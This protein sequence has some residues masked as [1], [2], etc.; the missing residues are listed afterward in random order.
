V[1]NKNWFD[2]FLEWVEG[3]NLFRLIKDNPYADRIEGLSDGE[4]FSL[5]QLKGFKKKINVAMDLPFPIL[6]HFFRHYDKVPDNV[7]IDKDAIKAKLLKVIMEDG[8]TIEHFIDAVIEGN[9]IVGVGLIT[10]GDKL[11]DYCYNKIK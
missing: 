11:K 4:V 2:T 10:L 3:T 8:A 6:L 5:H 7:T 1:I 9:S